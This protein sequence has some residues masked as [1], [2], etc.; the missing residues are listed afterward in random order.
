MG[1][2]IVR[3]SV[4]MISVLPDPEQRGSSVRAALALAITALALGASCGR[5]PA[6]EKPSAPAAVAPQTPRDAQA[7]AAAPATKPV[8]PEPQ[9]PVGLSV[10]D[11]APDFE[12]QD[13]EGT[14]FKLSDYRGKVVVL[15]FWGFW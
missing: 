9:I 5:E 13:V 2:L 3:Y 1:G 4:E 12:A 14:R 15:D 6:A 7:V 10:G 8:A 11:R